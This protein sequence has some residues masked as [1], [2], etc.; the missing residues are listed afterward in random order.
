MLCHYGDW[1]RGD[2][3]VPVGVDLLFPGKMPS[4]RAALV[5]AQCLPS[6]A[7]SHPKAAELKQADERSVL[8][9]FFL[10]SLNINPTIQIVS[11]FYWVLYLAIYFSLGSVYS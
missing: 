7:A 10:P 9:S 4:Q 6:G 2:G 3:S 11:L 1:V 5:S 8:V